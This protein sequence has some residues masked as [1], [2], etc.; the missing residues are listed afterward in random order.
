MKSAARNITLISILLVI[1]FI[2][3][4]SQ[5]TS[6][7]P[8]WQKGVSYV[9]Y[10]WAML[11]TTTS[12]SSIQ[13]MASD[14]VNW[15][16]LCISWIQD[17]ETTTIKFPDDN[18]L[19]AQTKAIKCAVDRFH[20]KHINVMLKPMIN[21]RNH[22]WRA[23]I[24]PSNAWFSSY[25]SYIQFWSKLATQQH[26]E[27]LCIGCEFRNTQPWDSSWRMIAATARAH[28]KGPLTY[29]PN[30]DDYTTVKWWDAVD[31]IGIDAYFPLTTTVHPTLSELSSGWALQADNIESWRNA[32]YP[33][34]PV[35]FTEIG[36][37]SADSTNITP[38]EG[39]LGDTNPNIQRDCYDACLEVMT[40]RKW[41]YGIYWWSWEINPN[42]GGIQDHGFSPQNKPAE[43]VLKTWYSKSLPLTNIK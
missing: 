22:K 8:V 39:R 10:R 1:L 43:T 3:S 26:A 30:W 33:T 23:A 40:Q 41:F 24:E 19:Q 6:F 15:V 28:Y 25:S 17:N 7:Q 20:A 14:S 9:A 16:A 2:S 5:A 21:L 18:N 32:N 38:W 35:I 4:S 37:C 42:A 34:R 13:M 27:A 11:T 12:D 31:Y 36:Y 29:A